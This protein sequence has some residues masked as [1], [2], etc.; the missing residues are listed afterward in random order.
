MTKKHL[1]FQTTYENFRYRAE[2]RFNAYDL[3]CFSNFFEVFCTEVKPSRNNFRAFVQEEVHRPVLPSER[4]A[5]SEIEDFSAN[6][7]PKVEEDLDIGEDLL[8]IS[9]R[10]NIELD[11]DVQSRGSNGTPENSMMV[12]SPMASGHRAPTIKSEN[13]H[14]SCVRSGS[15]EIAPDVLVN[16]TFTD[17]SYIPSSETRL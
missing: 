9:Q 11:Q 13:R 15:W 7:R 8:K 2:N 12:D 3:G 14:S 10:R 17:R 16:S 5:E 4:G 1:I 6:P